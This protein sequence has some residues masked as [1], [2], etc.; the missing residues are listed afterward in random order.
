LLDVVVKKVLKMSLVKVSVETTESSDKMLHEIDLSKSVEENVKSICKVFGKEY[1]SVYGLK[2]ISTNDGK[3][4]HIYITDDNIHEIK[5]GYFLQLAFSVSF[6]TKRIFDHVDGQYKERSFQ[7]LYQL[8]VDPEF[9]KEIVKTEKHIKLMDVFTNTELSVVE[10]TACLI[11]IV[12]L[13]QKHYLNEMSSQLLRKVISFIK[14]STHLELIKYALSVIHKVLCHRNPNFAQLKEEIITEIS[15][16]NL[17]EHIK[18]VMAPEIQY[19]ALLAINSLI[20]SCK[21]EKRQQLIKELNLRK[22]RENIYQHIIASGNVNNKKVDKI[23]AHELYICQT[24]LLSIYAEALAITITDQPDLFALD[25][26]ELP[27]E[28]KKMT[29]LM[30]FDDSAMKNKTASIDNLLDHDDVRISLAS[31]SSRNSEASRLSNRIR[32]TATSESVDLES[33]KPSLLTI[34][35]LSE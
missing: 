10:A 16:E 14:H 32:S 18:K 26:F 13:F 8:S 9:I 11:C 27:S 33:L 7:D 28:V 6:Y 17:T 12:H 23:L 24:F 35:A 2:L 19:G 20:R 21:G 3:V 22:H 34:E 1:S 30:D 25:E 29:L 31:M 15:I 4:L 5:D